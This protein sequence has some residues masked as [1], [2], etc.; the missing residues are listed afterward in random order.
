M[1]NGN[2]GEPFSGK[3]EV[4]QKVNAFSNGQAEIS[5]IKIIVCLFVPLIAGCAYLHDRARDT[6]DIVTVSG[7]VGSVNASLQIFKGMTGLGGGEGEGFGFRSG[8]LGQYEYEEAHLVAFG[9]KGFLPQ[10][11]DSRCKAYLMDY[12]WHFR[13]KHSPTITIKE[14]LWHNAWQIELAVSLGVGV[15]AGINFAELL[16]FLL[17]WSMLDICRDDVATRNKVEEES[18]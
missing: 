14:G 3:G 12:S 9:M 15:R 1:I 18:D 6:M 10:D 8:V 16:D 7:E 17:G 2:I 13:D 5:L 4:L 11:E